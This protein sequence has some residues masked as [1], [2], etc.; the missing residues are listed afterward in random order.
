MYNNKPKIVYI[1][2][3]IRIYIYI[4]HTYHNVKIYTL[5]T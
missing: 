2:Y 4:Y 5:Y 3:Y 1:M